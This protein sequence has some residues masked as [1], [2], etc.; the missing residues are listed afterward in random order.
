M[1]AGLVY[2]I[3]PDVH[4]SQ[5]TWLLKIVSVW[6]YVCVCVCVC[7]YSCVYLPPNLLITSGVIWTPYDWLNKF[8]SCYMTTVVIITNGY[9]LGID[10]C[11]RN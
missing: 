11:H 10:M 5:F 9:G 2:I 7:V 1:P 6:T 8:Y 3:K 4:R